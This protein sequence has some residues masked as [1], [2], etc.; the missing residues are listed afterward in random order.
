MYFDD[1]VPSQESHSAVNLTNGIAWQWVN[2]GVFSARSENRRRDGGLRWA[3]L[4]PLIARHYN[5]SRQRGRPTLPDTHRAAGPDLL[6]IIRVHLSSVFI[7]FVSSLSCLVAIPLL[8]RST[9]KASPWRF[10]KTIISATLVN[11]PR[12]K[13][14]SPSEESLEGHQARRRVVKACQR[15]RLRKC[16][17][18]TWPTPIPTRSQPTY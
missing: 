5:I 12:L 13:A 6:T 10:G 15:C 17:V 7:A 9:Q 1:D 14:Q 18:R 11:M 4:Q 8:H 16:K 2:S 3:L